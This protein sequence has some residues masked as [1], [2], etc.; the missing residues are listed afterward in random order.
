M[1]CIFGLAGLLAE[2]ASPKTCYIMVSPVLSYRY[3]SGKASTR[4]YVCPYLPMSRCTKS[5]DYKA[6]KNQSS[7]PCNPKPTQYSPKSLEQEHGSP[8][9]FPCRPRKEPRSS[10]TKPQTSTRSPWAFN[11]KITTLGGCRRRLLPCSGCR[12]HLRL[13]W[14]FSAES[15]RG[16]TKHT[17]SLSF[18]DHL[19]SIA[20]IL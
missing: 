12:Q 11:P 13:L 20:A 8:N 5:R 10:A 15:E 1:P 18:P 9:C 14:G 4:S 16:L 17:N 6:F 3:N 2:G 7:I 19:R